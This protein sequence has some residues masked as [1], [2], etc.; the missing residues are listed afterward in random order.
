MI[1][2]LKICLIFLEDVPNITAKLNYYEAIYFHIATDSLYPNSLQLVFITKCINNSEYSD[3]T[4]ISLILCVTAQVDIEAGYDTA[5]LPS[6]TTV[7]G[8]PTYEEAMEQQTLGSSSFS[9]SH[10]DANPPPF[11]K[12]SVGEFLEIYREDVKK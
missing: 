4:A 2:A 3:C 9:L 5:S 8:L 7:G 1:S 12:L 6:Y 11:S 10:S